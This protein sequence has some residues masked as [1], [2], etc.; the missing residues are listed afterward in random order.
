MFRIFRF[1]P[2]FLPLILWGQPPERTI[3]HQIAP[4]SIFK[5]LYPGYGVCKVKLGELDDVSV[6]TASTGQCLVKQ[7]V[8][9]APG[10]CGTGGAGT[11]GPAGAGV[12][13]GGTLGQLL[14]KAGATDYDTQ[15]IDPFTLNAS[16]TTAIDKASLITQ[17]AL[18]GHELSFAS[19]DATTKSVTIPGLT[20]YD[21]GTQQGRIG[22]ITQLNFK[23]AGVT[24]AVDG[25]IRANVTISGGGSSSGGDGRFIALNS[26]PTDLSSYASGQVLRINTPAPGKWMEVFGAD[27]SERHSFQTD[28]TSDPT[29]PNPLQVGSQEN[30]GYSSFGD[31]YGSLRTADGGQAL[32][33]DRTP[34]MRFELQ[35]TVV[36]LPNTKH[37]RPRQLYL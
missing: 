27:N 6:S 16:Q 21:E 24:A 35:R 19:S 36:R 4:S 1:F 26:Q 28:F 33:A 3:D 2:L 23:G 17:I 9:W 29:N 20:L 13:R 10:Q 30:Y 7:A 12:A 25:A 5:T 34:V 8:G 18:S 32:P 31:I 11:P 37:K 14:A 15:W 22:N